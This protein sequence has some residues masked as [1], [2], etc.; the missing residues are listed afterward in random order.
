MLQGAA[1][2]RYAELP[3]PSDEDALAE[4]FI[5][6]WMAGS[7][8]TPEAKEALDRLVRGTL[9]TFAMRAASRA[10]RLRD[11]QHL[12]QGLTALCIGGA[13]SDS[14]DLQQVACAL[15]DGCLRLGVDPAVTFREAAGQARGGAAWILSE[16]G[17]LPPGEVTLPGHRVREDKDE[18]GFRYSIR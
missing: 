14:R 13:E 16:F 3:I 10:V 5:R 17:G 7:S 6:E 12:R 4:E 11:P 15:Y 2:R 9:L 8:S 18:G 1:L